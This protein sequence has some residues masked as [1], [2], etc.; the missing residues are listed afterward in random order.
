ML[1]S[2]VFDFCLII[3]I[4]EQATHLRELLSDIENLF[5]TATLRRQPLARQ[6]PEQ[7]ILELGRGGDGNSCLDAQ[8]ETFSAAFFFAFLL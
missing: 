1:T 5:T 8:T 4:R 7:D 6:M 3:T 2:L